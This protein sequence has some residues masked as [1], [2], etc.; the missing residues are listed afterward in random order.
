[1]DIWWITAGGG[2]P[3][4][5]KLLIHK[6]VRGRPP[7]GFKFEIFHLFLVPGN[8]INIYKYVAFNVVPA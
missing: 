1:M 8:N 2:D 6:A 4:D 7:R 5:I 3:Q